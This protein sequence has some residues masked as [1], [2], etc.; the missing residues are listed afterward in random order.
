MSGGTAYVLD[1]QTERVNSRR[2][3]P[4]SW[5]CA[6]SDAEDA[7]IL[8]DLLVQHVAETDSPLAARLLEN[9]DDTA[10]RITKVLPRDYAAVLQTRKTPSTRGSTPT[11]T[12]SGLASWR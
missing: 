8:R 4:A 2:S 12:S 6:N 3:R 10:A 7:E 1:L 5:S 9:F 11:A